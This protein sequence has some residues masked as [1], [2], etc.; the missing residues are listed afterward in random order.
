MKACIET[1]AAITNDKGLTEIVASLVCRIEE[2]RSQQF[3]QE[4]EACKANLFSSVPA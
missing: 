4:F 3:R 2:T 1:I